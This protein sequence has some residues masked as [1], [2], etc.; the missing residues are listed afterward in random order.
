MLIMKNIKTA[1]N[2]L[3]SLIK[4]PTKGLP[5]EIFAFVSTITPLVNVDLLIK[6]KKNQTLLTWRND[7]Y[8]PAGWHIP[9]GIMRYKETIADR[10][11]AV[12]ANELGVNIRFKKDPLA[13]GEI[14]TSRKFRGHAISLL[15][16]CTLTTSPIKDLEYKKGTP[17]SGEWAWH[18]KCPDNILSVQEIYR[19]FI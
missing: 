15:Y 19:K 16:E 9:G 1:I 17:K 12:A 13:V 18:N 14:M 8:N 5:D 2:F 4:N 11:S 10:L 7:G 6:N 3:E